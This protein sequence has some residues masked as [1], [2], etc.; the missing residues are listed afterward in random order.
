MDEPTVGLPQEETDKVMGIV[1]HVAETEGMSVVIIEHDLELIWNVCSHV[2]FMADG[3]IMAQG[4]PDELRA[5]RMVQEKY[6][7]EGDA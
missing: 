4:S 3:R 2:H 1:R 5:S 6:M 7:G